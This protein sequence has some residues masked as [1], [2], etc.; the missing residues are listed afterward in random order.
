MAVIGGKWLYHMFCIADRADGA[1]RVHQGGAT[2]L[3]V[4]QQCNSPARVI[5][6]IVG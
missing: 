4:S 1:R 6:N 3:L 5:S 2:C